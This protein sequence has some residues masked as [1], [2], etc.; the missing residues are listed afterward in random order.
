MLWHRP[1]A[2][3]VQ[4]KSNCVL[5]KTTAKAPPTA[6]NV[7]NEYK[8]VGRKSAAKHGAAATAL[9]NIEHAR[10]NYIAQRAPENA[11]ALKRQCVPKSHKCDVD[12]ALFH[13]RGL[14]TLMSLRKQMRPGNRGDHRLECLC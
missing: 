9:P 12:C 6:A 7:Q 3:D 14:L 4:N 13:Q 8:G 5:R 1:T 11:N 10:D 2:A